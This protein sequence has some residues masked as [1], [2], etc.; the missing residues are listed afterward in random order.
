MPTAKRPRRTTKAKSADFITFIVVKKSND[1]KSYCMR[2]YSDDPR[3]KVEDDFCFG[4][5]WLFESMAGLVM[6]YKELGLTIHW[7]FREE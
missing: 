2:I 7:E 5:S 6:K 4:E 3:A 1:F